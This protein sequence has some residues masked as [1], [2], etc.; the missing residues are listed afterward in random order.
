MIRELA[1]IFI[2]I[3]LGLWF[4][5]YNTA[6]KIAANRI[7]RNFKFSGGFIK[8][9]THLECRDSSHTVFMDF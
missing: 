7:I 3:D 6:L 5:L 1:L 2:I 4:M 9:H 8:T